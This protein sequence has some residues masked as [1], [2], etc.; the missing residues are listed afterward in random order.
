MRK[1]RIQ[2]EAPRLI[3]E[4]GGIIRTSQAL[5]MGI[6]PR[7]FYKLRDE[8]ILEKVS[9]GVYR[10][11]ELK[12]ILNPDLIA[13]STRVP[14]SVICLVSALAFHEMTT[15]IPHEVS[16]ALKRGSRVPRL[17][18]P[19]VSIF[20]FNEKPF[21]SG[22]EIHKI[23]GVETKIYS[24]EKTIADCF[25]FRNQIGMDIVLEALKIYKSKGKFKIDKLLKYAKVCRV[26]RIMKPY[27][28]AML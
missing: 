20:L 17:K 4:K 18:F 8:G 3:A 10:L 14:Q 15:Q 27:L 12:P 21:Y 11:V 28:E 5:K 22:I 24:P 7:T 6:Y 23:D 2:K 19:P 25:K 13:I 1:K 16:I 9:R 26:E